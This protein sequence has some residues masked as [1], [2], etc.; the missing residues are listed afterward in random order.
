MFQ[1]HIS[2]PPK[3]YTCTLRGEYERLESCVPCSPPS[4]YATIFSSSI[5]FAKGNERAGRPRTQT[6]SGRPPIIACSPIR[7]GRCS[8]CMCI[9]CA[10][11]TER[12]NSYPTYR[13]LQMMRGSDSSKGTDDKNGKIFI[14]TDR[15]FRGGRELL[16]LQ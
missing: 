15:L 1:K 4:H 7:K 6:F 8:R 13:P 2:P 3:L 10:H 11:S 14:W 12:F 5:P 9:T 16:R